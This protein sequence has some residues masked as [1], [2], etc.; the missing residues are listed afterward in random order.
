MA[1]LRALVARD[2]ALWD[3]GGGGLRGLCPGGVV[4]TAVA[5]PLTCPPLGPSFCSAFVDSNTSASTVSGVITV[6]LEAPAATGDTLFCAV[7]TW[8]SGAALGRA[9]TATVQA[10]V[11]LVPVP[12]TPT[13]PGGTV[14]AQLTLHTGECV[15]GEGAGA[16]IGTAAVEVVDC[17]NTPTAQLVWCQDWS[18][19]LPACSPAEAA[20]Q[21]PNDPTLVPSFRLSATFTCPMQGVTNAF[22]SLAAVAPSR[23][24]F[25]ALQVTE[26]AGSGGKTWDARFQL[27]SPLFSNSSVTVTFASPSLTNNITPRCACAHSRWQRVRVRV[28]CVSVCVLPR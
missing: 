8:A 22:L 9:T 15:N 28:G 14:L 2:H 17:S 3:R 4:V 1:L 25:S 10:G 6:M 7:T 24:R 27:A 20:L 13:P 16:Q 23:Y 12:S 21:A 26:V 11:L 18:D 5:R 19:T